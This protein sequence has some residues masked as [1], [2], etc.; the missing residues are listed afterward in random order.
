MY[1]HACSCSQVP[2]RMC[3]GL[4]GT[5]GSQFLQCVWLRDCSQGSQVWQQAPLHAEPF[6][7]SP[8]LPFYP[9]YLLCTLVERAHTPMDYF[10]VPLLHY[11]AFCGCLCPFNNIL[12]IYCKLWIGSIYFG[13]SVFAFSYIKIVFSLYIKQLVLFCIRS[14]ASFLPLGILSHARVLLSKCLTP[15]LFPLNDLVFS[16]K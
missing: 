4:K 11:A 6:H 15:D 13:C 14:L 16:L 2:W 7:W 8:L 1:V 12:I 10:L 3:G 9:V 5:L